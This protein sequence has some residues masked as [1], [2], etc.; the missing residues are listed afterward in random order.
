[1]GSVSPLKFQQ[2]RFG[3]QRFLALCLICFCPFLWAAQDAIVISDEALVFADEL[4]TSP[5][6]YVRKGKKIRIGNIPRNRAQVYPI[7]VSG[8]VAYIRALDVSTQRQSMSNNL[9]VAERFQRGTQDEKK[10]NYTLS[11]FNYASQI[12][13]N[14]ENDNIQDKD[15]VNWTGLSLQGGV[16]VAG[17]ND[18]DFYINYM[19]AQESK[20]VF[21]AVEFGG[22]WS[23]RMLEQKR[24]Q[25]KLFTQL[26]A[27]PFASYAL[28]D[29]FRVN[30]YGFSSGAGLSGKY[31][32]G[33][34]WAID[35]HAGFFYTKL[36]GFGSPA[37]Y[38]SIEPS[39]MG[40]RLGLG[41]SYQY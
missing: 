36:F 21:Q 4:M 29:L 41:M 16:Q 30:G 35:A 9:L 37:P 3:L 22:G 2:V 13:L 40:T 10:Y 15:A 12:T 7:V 17:R 20:E 39:F 19:R 25:L 5:V 14:L 33:S 27:V 28:D 32:L 8:K 26:L 24:F 38:N 23:F 6:G 1:M 18:L 31:R 11:F 34:N